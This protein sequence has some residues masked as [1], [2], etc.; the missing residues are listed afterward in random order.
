M[1]NGL[2]HKGDQEAM[3]EATL[4][5]IS[6]APE[7]L[8]DKARMEQD[9]ENV[10][11][12]D[13]QASRVMADAQLSPIPML[14][15]TSDLNAVHTPSSEQIDG[16]PRALNKK[17]EHSP[18]PADVEDGSL[19]QAGPQLLA[20]VKSPTP[21]S[22]KCSKCQKRKGAEGCHQTACLA[23]CDDLTCVPHKRP[24]EYAAWKA[25][26]LQGSTLIQ[27]RAAELRSRRIPDKRRFVKEPGFVYT[28]DTI[29]IWNVREY[30]ANPKWRDDAIRKCS[31]RLE[32]NDCGKL[33]VTKRL[34]NS[35][36][37]FR[38]FIEKRM[39]ESNMTS[40]ESGSV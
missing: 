25:Q 31:R 23:C 13:A 20:S 5:T 15:T 26:V 21:P 39:Q 9:D 35:R 28:G 33:A 7:P 32:R 17:T 38:Q 24:R 10:G 2:F 8:V 27:Q 6:D 4:D 30:L 40:I 3:K 14:Q 36:E 16:N 29:V 34:G 19:I 22:S 18:A 12:E 1:G 11:M 37:R